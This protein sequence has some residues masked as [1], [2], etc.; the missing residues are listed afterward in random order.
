MP[1]IK[2]IWTKCQPLVGI[3]SGWHFVR[4]A[5]CPVGILSYHRG[6][7]IITILHGGVIEIHYNI[8][9]GGPNL[10]H[11]IWEGVKKLTFYGQADRKGGEGGSA[12]T[13]SLAAKCQ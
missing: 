1:T 9:W 10:Y 11:V 12:F 3:L 7:Y 5:I 4:L 2:K 13:F 8:T 6:D